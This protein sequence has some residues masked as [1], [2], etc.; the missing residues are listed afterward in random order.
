MTEFNDPYATAAAQLAAVDLSTYQARLQELLDDDVHLEATIVATDQLLREKALEITKAR[1]AGSDGSA[2]A[3]ALLAGDS[4]ITAAPTLQALEAEK[5]VMNSGLAELRRRRNASV[6][7]KAA[8]R[9]DQRKELA[10]AVEPVATALL[11]RAGELSSELAAVFAE[12]TALS[13]ATGNAAAARL[14]RQLSD[15]LALL[16]TEGAV[17]RRGQLIVHGETAS[18]L[19]AARPAIEFAH[20]RIATEVAFPSP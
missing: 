9:E 2:A 1:V 19:E 5:D 18:M 12:A 8:V 14:A 15:P 4:V 13:V 17:L 20:G 10:Q 7:A 6:G 3:D 11:V 16:A